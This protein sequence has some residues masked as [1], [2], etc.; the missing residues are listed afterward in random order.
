[1]KT[2]QQLSVS[3][4]LHKSYYKLNSKATYFPVLGAAAFCFPSFPSAAAATAVEEEE[5]EE[6]EGGGAEEGWAGREEVGGFLPDRR[7]LSSS[8]LTSFSES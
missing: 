5:E 2:T 6:E 8:R 7:I 4:A 3:Y 1:M